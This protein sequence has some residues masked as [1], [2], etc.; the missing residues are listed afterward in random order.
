MAKGEGK[1][2]QSGQTYLPTV[3]WTCGVCGCKAWE[4]ATNVT[5]RV[6]EK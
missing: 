6:E 2:D 1:L 5:H 3:V 4:P